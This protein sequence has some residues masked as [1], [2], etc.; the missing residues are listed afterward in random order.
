MFEEAL[1]VIEDTYNGDLPEL[2]KPSTGSHGEVERTLDCRVHD[3]DYRAL[4][5][6]SVD[7]TVVC[8][9][10]LSED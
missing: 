10:V 7:S 2:M 5:V 9:V 6:L 1:D 8:V 4:I 3:L